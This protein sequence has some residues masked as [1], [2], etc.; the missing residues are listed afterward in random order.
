MGG[1]V[2]GVTWES[3]ARRISSTEILTEGRHGVPAESLK[4]GNTGLRQL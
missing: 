3:R 2:W 4:L 1:G